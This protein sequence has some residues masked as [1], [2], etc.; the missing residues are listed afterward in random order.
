MPMQTDNDA[1]EIVS[2]VGCLAE[3]LGVFYTQ[4]TKHRLNSGQALS[5]TSQLL[6]ILVDHFFD[7]NIY[8]MDDDAEREDN[9]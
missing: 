6:G 1:E 3:L 7:E 5:L 8:W 4:L 2:L 9:E